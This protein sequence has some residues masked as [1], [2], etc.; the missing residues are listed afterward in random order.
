M[1]IGVALISFF[2]LFGAWM[3]LPASPKT[4][5]HAPKAKLDVVSRSAA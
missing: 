4:A 2:A 5:V 1:E 3:V